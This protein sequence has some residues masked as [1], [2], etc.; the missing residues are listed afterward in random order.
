[1]ESQRPEV[2]HGIAGRSMLEHV[3]AAAYPL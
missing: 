2:L 1:M 3:L